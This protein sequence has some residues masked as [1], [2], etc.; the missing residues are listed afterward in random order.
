M[1]RFANKIVTLTCGLRYS[2]SE[3]SKILLVFR[4]LIRTF[5]RRNKT[6][7]FVNKTN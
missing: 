6:S 5:A 1:P 3:K 7:L 4:S 2:R